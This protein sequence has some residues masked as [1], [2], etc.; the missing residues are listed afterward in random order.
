[1]ASGEN[2]GLNIGVISKKYREKGKIIGTIQGFL[3][4]LQ[5]IY[6][7]CRSCDYAIKHLQRYIKHKST[8]IAVAGVQLLGGDT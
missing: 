1:M 7:L 5:Q 6:I 3:K 8:T 2:I 4:H